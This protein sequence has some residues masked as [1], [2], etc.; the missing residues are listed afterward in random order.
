MDRQPEWIGDEQRLPDRLPGGI[1][2]K[3]GRDQD[4]RQDQQ[5]RQPDAFERYALFH[6]ADW[7]IRG[8]PEWPETITARLVRKW[9]LACPCCDKRPP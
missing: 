5:K 8:L 7:A 9:P 3:N 6:L 1:K 2:E 4:L